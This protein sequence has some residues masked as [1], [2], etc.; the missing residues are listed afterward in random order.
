MDYIDGDPFTITID[1][2][3][4]DAMEQIRRAIV[5]RFADAAAGESL[6]RQSAKGRRAFVDA[7]NALAEIKQSKLYRASFK[8][9]D[10]YCREKWG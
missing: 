1:N 7:G 6:P 9:F 5:A 2:G 10:D 8:T 4:A 3:V